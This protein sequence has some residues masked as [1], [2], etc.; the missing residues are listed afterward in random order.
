MFRSLI[1][2]A[3]LFFAFAA[4][5]YAQQ[6]AVSAQI[7]IHAD[8]PGAKIS[9][10]IYSQFSEHL[11]R[12]VY[13]GIW[14]GPGSRIP[15]TR[16]IR[17]DVVAALRELQVPALRWPGGCFGELYHW[18]DGVGPRPQRPVRLNYFWGGVEES[19]AFG[20]HE[21]FDFLGQIGA[22]AYVSA[23]VGT[24][25]PAEMSDWV[26]YM[27]SASHSALAQQR[28]A[29][30][31]EEPWSV[32]FLGIG[33]ESWG[34][35]GDMTPEFYADL[36]KQYA[37]FAR[38]GRDPHPAVVAVGPSG[39][40]YH[41]TE[42]VMAQAASKMDAL[43]LHH[44]S[45]P[46]GDWSRHGPAR[47]FGEDQW[48][49]TLAQ[50]L[51]MEEFVTRHSAIM[52]RY[53]PQKRVALF[54]DEWGT[55]YDP[56]GPS[57]GL[58]QSNTLRD[59]IVAGVNLDIFQNHADRVRLAAIAQTM[60]VLQAMILTDGPRM[61]RTPT[62]WTF[63]MYRP[64]KETTSLPSE[65]DAPAYRLGET[66]APSIHASAARAE[67]GKIIVALVNLDPNRAATITGRIVG[68]DASGVS[69]QILTSGAM[70]A[71]NTFDAPDAVVPAPFTG[72][73]VAHDRL[74]VN[75][76]AKS[77]VVLTIQ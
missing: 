25:T 27:T 5:A 76:P 4:P 20:T 52:D 63:M 68:A 61:V 60:N 23:N 7:T 51:R 32:P 59:A 1:A 69:G 22:D 2:L 34:C 39:D 64:F 13:D 75:L 43:S 71:Q 65:V 67:D 17:N 66:T 38:S 57:S 18:R 40:D 11:G 58:F 16:G 55:W 73:A 36:L 56:E 41:W 42:V 19:N 45:L 77:V 37:V 33:N 62:Y 47:G 9:R 24:G 12:G 3:A 35:G 46:T 8:R 72:A 6:Q 10:Y 54:V 15:N 26:E 53:D 70:D 14:V 49:A 48:I 21:Y 44:Y 50:T 30:G 28:R 29:N 31:R 74:T